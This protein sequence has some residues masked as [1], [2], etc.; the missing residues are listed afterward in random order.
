MIILHQYQLAK[1]MEMCNC[2]WQ[3]NNRDGVTRLGRTRSRTLT[4]H[5]SLT[6]SHSLTA[7]SVGSHCHTHSKWVTLT[8]SFT[9]P[10]SHQWVRRSP[11]SQRR[12][13]HWLSEISQS[14]SQCR[15]SDPRVTQWLSEWLT[16]TDHSVTDWLSHS[17]TQWSVSDPPT[18][19]SL[20]Q[21]VTV[22][23]LD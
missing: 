8:G 13:S 5:Y 14:L 4:S 10:V 18:D 6:Q 12:E 23:W 19:W 11:P 2:E 21:W 15:A 17:L 9:D 3:A 1:P 20:R 22:V 7:Q 16:V